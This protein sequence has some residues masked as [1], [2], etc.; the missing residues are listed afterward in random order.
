MAERTCL[1]C[2]CDIAH[3]R[4]NAK[5]CSDKC[6]ATWHS[7]NADRADECSV[8]GCG[9]HDVIIESGFCTPHHRRV[10]RSGEVGSAY[11]GRPRGD[12][13]LGRGECEVDGCIATARAAGMCVNHRRSAKLYGDP[14]VRFKPG[15]KPGKAPRGEEAS[16]WRGGTSAYTAVHGRLRSA[17]GHA[18]GHACVDCGGRAAEWSYSHASDAEQVDAK[19]R[20]YSDDLGDYEPRCIPCHRLFDSAMR[21]R[22]A[23]FACS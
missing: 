18:N 21:G 2:G 12:N 5:F 3:R 14:L 17:F 11:V 23:R 16:G 10:K 4:A 9:R 20:I 8:N 1:H 15:H 13:S 19:G 7:R 22:V 6:C